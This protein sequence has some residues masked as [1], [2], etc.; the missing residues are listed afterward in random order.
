MTGDVVAKPGHVNPGV[1]GRQSEGDVARDTFR[2]V[3]GTQGS[4]L[5]L[6]A[7]HVWP[8]GHASPVTGTALAFQIPVP[9]E[10]V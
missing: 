1:Q 7:T 10:H 3:P 9:T 6:P 8:R 5:V 2:K 4:G